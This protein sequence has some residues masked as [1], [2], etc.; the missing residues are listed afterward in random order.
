MR[1][2]IEKKEI[3]APFHKCLYLY[4]QSNAFTLIQMMSEWLEKSPVVSGHLKWFRPCGFVSK[5][6]RTQWQHDLQ[7]LE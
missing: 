1:P 7:L 3:K 5:G 2:K 4:G 6:F